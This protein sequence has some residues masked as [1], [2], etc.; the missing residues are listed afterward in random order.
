MAK[1]YTAADLEAMS[2]AERA[3]AIKAAVVTDPGEM[4]QE[5]LARGRERLA[6]RFA[7]LDS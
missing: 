5:M 2:A 1:R 7:K 6:E 3:E 4:D